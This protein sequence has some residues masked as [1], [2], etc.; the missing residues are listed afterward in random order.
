MAE[1][2]QFKIRRRKLLKMSAIF[3]T[4]NFIPTKVSESVD[5]EA[6]PSCCETPSNDN[7]V[8]IASM[9]IPA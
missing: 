2:N 9:E 7:G 6:S 1:N 4:G 5:A 8:L 3:G